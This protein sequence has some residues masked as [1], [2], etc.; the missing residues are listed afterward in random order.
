MAEQPEQQEGSAGN[1]GSNA[2]LGDLR[3]RIDAIDK[4]LVSLLNERAQI[5]ATVGKIK[6]ETGIPIY[7]PHREAVRTCAFGQGAGEMFDF[8]GGRYLPPGRAC[9]HAKVQVDGCDEVDVVSV[10]MLKLIVPKPPQRAVPA[11]H[12]PSGSHA[13]QL[14]LMPPPRVSPVS[15]W[16]GSQSRSSRLLRFLWTSYCFSRRQ[17]GRQSR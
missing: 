12:A 6:R 14:S 17:V 10:H 7:A 1:G 2:V 5:V 16:C 11:S 3:E 9:H 15:W 8:P 13:R 4:Q